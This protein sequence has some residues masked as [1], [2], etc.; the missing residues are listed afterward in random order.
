VKA[1]IPSTIKLDGVTYRVTSIGKKAFYKN[2][3]IQKVTIGKNITKIGKKAF[4]GCSSLK[5]IT[6][7]TQ[8]LT[9][10]SVDTSAFTKI[11]KKAKI[12]LPAAKYK[13]YKKILKKAGAGSKAKFYKQ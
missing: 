13:T 8:K 6:V 4:Y 1:T 11:Y 9:S 5:R 7:K 10:D 3:N 12:Y 2:T